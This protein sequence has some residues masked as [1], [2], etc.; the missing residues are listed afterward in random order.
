[1]PDPIYSKARSL[2]AIGLIVPCLL[3]TIPAVIA[4][5]AQKQL[6]GSFERVSH[7]IEVQRE[8]QHLRALILEAESSQRGY[9]LGSQDFHLESY[10]TAIRQ[11]QSQAAAIRM[12]TADNPVQQENNR[13]LEPLLATKLD[14]M[15]KVVALQ[16]RGDAPAVQALVSSS[17][18]KQAMVAIENHL[19]QMGAEESRLLIA[20][21]ERL[22]SSG[23][24]STIF[25]FS[26]VG[27]S[28]IFAVAVSV[29]LHRLSKIQSL[30]T[31]CAWSRTVEY[32]GEWLS[33]EEY[34]LR[35]FN[36]NT[37]HGISPAEAEKAFGYVRRKTAQ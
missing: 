3:I 18:G 31:V 36:L 7:T 13:T 37:S 27:L 30:V 33:F 1:M 5:R 14:F 29:M 17:R 16:E 25:L 28:L 23:R 8:L 35:R 34:L 22:T 2:L 11:L 26:L 4:Y 10:R 20:R 6:A 24:F 32:E 15:A 21:E 19:D 9:L 12:L